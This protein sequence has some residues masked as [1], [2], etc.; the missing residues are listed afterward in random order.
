[1]PRLCTLFLALALLAGALPGS[2]GAV[3]LRA[4]RA[5][6]LDWRIPGGHVFSV[7]PTGT[8]RAL[9]RIRL[10][11]AEVVV[12]PSG[13]LLTRSVAMLPARPEQRP[14]PDVDLV[15]LPLPAAMPLFLA[16]L[17]GLFLAGRPRRRPPKTAGP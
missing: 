14:R 16:A 7:G 13:R 2:A 10:V 9:P 17:A 8:V 3:P 1:M 6:D 11:T 4:D 12:L 15:V 5:V